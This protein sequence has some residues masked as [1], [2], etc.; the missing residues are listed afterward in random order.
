MSSLSDTTTRKVPLKRYEPHAGL[1]TV[2][3]RMLPF[4]VPFWV[5]W[6]L[7][8][9]VFYFFGLDMGPGVGIRIEG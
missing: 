5:A 3:S 2:I 6:V 9:A 8:L 7:V 1:G 4:V